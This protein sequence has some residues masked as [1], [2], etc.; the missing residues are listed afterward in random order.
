MAIIVREFEMRLTVDVEWKQDMRWTQRRTFGAAYRNDLFRQISLSPMKL[1]RS[2]VCQQ[3]CSVTVY[4][5]PVRR[6]GRNYL[7]NLKIVE[8]T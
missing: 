5:S 7:L 3:T 2:G 6:L 1:R 4:V 8:G